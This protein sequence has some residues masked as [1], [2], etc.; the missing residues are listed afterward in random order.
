MIYFVHFYFN[1]PNFVH[2]NPRAA[3]NPK[4]LINDIKNDKKNYI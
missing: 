4:T 1:V 2:L 3:E